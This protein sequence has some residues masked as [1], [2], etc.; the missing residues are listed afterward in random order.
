MRRVA[1]HG[2]ASSDQLGDITGQNLVFV[3]PKAVTRDSFHDKIIS[4]SMAKQLAKIFIDEAH[5]Y[6]TE[7]EFRPMFRE[8]PK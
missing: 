6:C 3:T 4:L 5:L 7:S 8:L 1:S 2:I